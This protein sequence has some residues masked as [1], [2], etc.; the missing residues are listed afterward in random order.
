MNSLASVEMRWF[1]REPPF[2]VSDY[3]DPE[4]QATP[5]VDWYAMPSDHGCGIKIR[6]GRLEAKLQV[7][8]LGERQFA[9]VVGRL[10]AW[11]K[12]SSLLPSDDVPPNELLDETNWIAVSKVRSIRLIK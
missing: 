1:F 5:R 6:E 11:K 12:W 4:H 10:D 9:N 3:F 7:A 8:D 2:D